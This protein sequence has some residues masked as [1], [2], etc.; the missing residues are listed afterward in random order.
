[1]KKDDLDKY[2]D[3]RKSRDEAF[4]TGFEEGYLHFKIGHLL[5]QY[6]LEAGL[7]LEEMARKLNTHKSAISRIENHSEDIRY[8]TLMKYASA[9]NKK[10][11]IQII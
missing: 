5:R 2:I 10:L 9:V 1:M 4:A 7:S 8:S 6:R 11:V 3:N